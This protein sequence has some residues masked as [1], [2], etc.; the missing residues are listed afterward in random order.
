[1]DF[2]IYAILLGLIPAIIAKKKG[3]SFLL[4]WFFGFA[5]FIVALPLILIKK[6]DTESIE[7]NLLK[8]GMKKCPY[9][10]ELVKSEASICKHCGKNF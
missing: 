6:P 1:M 10:A 2:I 5:L 7:K 4:W 9:C 3:K 8:E